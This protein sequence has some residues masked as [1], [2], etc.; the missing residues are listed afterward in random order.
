MKSIFFD[1]NPVILKFHKIRCKMWD[2][3]L[4]AA[5]LRLENI[6]RSGRWS[7][8]RC[9]VAGTAVFV[10]SSIDLAL[11]LQSNI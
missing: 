6:L 1:P 11:I 9:Y 5:W 3:V 7:A 4:D 2:W 8:K 10:C